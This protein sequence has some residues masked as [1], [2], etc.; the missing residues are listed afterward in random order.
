MAPASINDDE[1][2]RAS[3]VA[4]QQDAGSLGLED[5]Q[6]VLVACFSV[7]GLVAQLSARHPHLTVM[8]I[9]EASILSALSLVSRGEQW[10][11]VTTGHFW[12]KHLSDG[13]GE[14]L[15]CGSGG[16]HRNFC[17]VYSTG[18]SAGDLHAASHDEIQ[19]KVRAAT[20]RL[21]HAGNVACVVMGC[22]G[23]AGL[24]D[25]IRTAAQLVYGQERAA[26]LYVVD[27]VK[28]GILQ[29]HQTINSRNTFR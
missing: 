2:I 19:A 13:V 8:G 16:E 12:E 1:G 18:L 5:Y 3:A 7:H 11:I 10:G 14:F 25:T 20:T 27:G 4:V 15:G 22:G 9:F 23:M 24:E 28:A 17:G 26:K 21:L 29:L 6:G